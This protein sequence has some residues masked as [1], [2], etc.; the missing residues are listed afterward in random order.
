MN[1]I[2]KLAVPA[3]LPVDPFSPVPFENEGD[4]APEQIKKKKSASAE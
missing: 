4:L 2:D 1:V 3:V